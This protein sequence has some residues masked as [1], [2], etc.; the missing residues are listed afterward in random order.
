MHKCK[1]IA[2]TLA[3]ALSVSFSVQQAAARASHMTEPPSPFSIVVKATG[4]GI[5][6][7]CKTGCAW[8]DVSATYPGGV[9]RITEMGIRPVRK[10]ADPAPGKQSESG[11]FSVILSTDGQGIRAT[12][13]DGCAWSTVRMTDPTSTYR[14]TEQGIEPVR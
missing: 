4:P 13:V 7:I 6:A 11:G 3:A 2:F 12:C 5:T 14:I 1:R 10:D 9:Y 8:E